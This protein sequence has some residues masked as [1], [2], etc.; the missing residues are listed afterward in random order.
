MPSNAGKSYRSKCS[1]PFLDSAFKSFFPWRGVS[2]MFG[3]NKF[4]RW[5]SKSHCRSFVLI[6]WVRAFSFGAFAGGCRWEGRRD[7]LSP[8]LVIF[9]TLIWLNKSMNQYANMI[10]KWG[11]FVLGQEEAH[12]QQHESCQNRIETATAT[13]CLLFSSAHRLVDLYL[14]QVLV[15]L[16]L[17]LL[18]Q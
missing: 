15:V 7:G 13:R 5:S 10:S 18:L 3:G 1:Q 14:L 2:W 4:E 16:D 12:H 17:P 8:Y 9:I 11:Q 6:F